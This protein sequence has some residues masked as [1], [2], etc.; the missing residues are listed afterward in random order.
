MCLV[1]LTT[2]KNIEE[3]KSLDVDILQKLNILRLAETSGRKY[4]SNF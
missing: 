2:T 3:I 4:I 1:I